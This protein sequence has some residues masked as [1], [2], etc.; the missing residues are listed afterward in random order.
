MF[1][2]F[3]RKGPKADPPADPPPA[4]APGDAGA[5]AGGARPPAPGPPRKQGFFGSLFGRRP[6]EGADQAAGDAA[7]AAEGSGEAE[8]AAAL[9]FEEALGED[10]GFLIPAPRRTAEGDEGLAPLP[11]DEKEACEAAEAEEQGEAF[12]A[13]DESDEEREALEDA[14]RA[15]AEARGAE[16]QAAAERE[17]RART[18]AGRAREAEARARAEAEAARETEARA[19]AA[20]E[21]A[22]AA[23]REARRAAEAAQEAEA[24]AAAESARAA[25]AK[26]EAEAR[27]KAEAEARER[28]EAEAGAEE[29][30]GG[31]RPSPARKG[32]F[33]RLKSRLSSTRDVI[34]GRIETVIGSRRAIDDEVLEELEEILYT[35]DL[36]PSTTAALLTKVKA[37]VAKNE[38][39]DAE[40]LKTALRDALVALMDVPQADLVPERPPRVLLVVGVNGVGKT[41]TIAK[42]AR[43]FTE[44]G[45]KVMLAAGDTFRAAAVEQLGVWA[46]RLG[47][48]F[49]SQPTGA[50][51]ASVV[52]DA[53]SSAKAKGSDVVIIDTAGRL[54][55]KANLMDELKKIKRVA[56]KAVPGAPHETILILDAHTGRNAAQQAKI[57]HSEIGVD[58]LIVTK[59]DGTSKGG[60]VVSV[61]HEHK[62][63]V[64]FIGIGE[65]YE[66]LRPFDPEAYANALMGMDLPEGDAGR[67]GAGGPPGAREG[68]A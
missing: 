42:L 20:T 59:L 65:G 64:I 13:D 18:E 58:S 40:A 50:D 68:G 41:T 55:T 36:G 19:R 45:Q 33:A 3:R 25:R 15:E 57:F 56:A 29:E 43:T 17:D 16:T 5:G 2:F 66:D 61:I 37:R 44:R 12:L 62:I 48:G 23:E 26:A 34:A 22:Q 21:A 51:A 9:G 6:K 38:L 54:H 14:R 46:E 30:V 39:A 53:L 31:D 10:A 35:A 7:A 67:E 63:P 11:A 60:M 28:A 24:R 49:V 27:E 32:W 4:P 8:D 52:F 1:D 47:C